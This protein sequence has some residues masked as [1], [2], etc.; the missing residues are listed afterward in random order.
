MPIGHFDDFP[1]PPTNVPDTVEAALQALEKAHDAPTANDA[2]D[3][4]LWAVGNN[5][6]GTY[7]PVVLGI[8]PAIHRILSDAQA[9][10]WAQHA[11]MEALIDLGGSFIP[12]QGHETYL[13]ACVKTTLQSSIELLRPAIASFINTNDART[14]SATDLL[15][16]M[17]DHTALAWIASNT[18]AQDKVVLH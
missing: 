15:E 16:L 10:T 8:F 12:E 9:N 18:A 3:S 11:T 7:Y 5:H 14:Q 13:G 6:A 2:Y 17:D 1:Q 4:I